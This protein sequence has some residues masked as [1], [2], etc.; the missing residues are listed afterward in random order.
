MRRV[1]NNGIMVLCMMGF[2]MGVEGRFNGGWY[3]EEELGV[4]VLCIMGFRYGS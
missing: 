2:D 4:M 3:E 1:W